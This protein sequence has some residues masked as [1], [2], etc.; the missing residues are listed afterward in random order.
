MLLQGLCGD[1][2][3]F[4][5]AISWKFRGNKARKSFKFVCITF[6]LY[7]KEFCLKFILFH[8]IL[9]FVSQGIIAGPGEFAEGVARGVKSLLGHVI[10]I[11]ESTTIYDNY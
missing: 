5:H 4:E 6:A 10:G 9:L 11:L 3:N 2:R 8:F 7:F 1:W